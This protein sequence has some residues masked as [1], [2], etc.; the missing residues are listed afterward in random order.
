MGWTKQFDK[1]I[2][3][4]LPDLKIMHNEPMK[5]HTSFRIGGP[6]VRMAFPKNGE[7]MVILLGFAEECGANPFVI[8][9]GTNLLVPDEGLER[10]VFDTSLMNQIE[11]GEEGRITAEAGVSLASSLLKRKVR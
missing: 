4:Y 2:E 1:L 8:G 9:N 7:Q 11:L 5:N 6:A 10:L 3:E